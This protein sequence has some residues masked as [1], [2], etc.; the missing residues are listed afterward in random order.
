MPHVLSPD[1]LARAIDILCAGTR[2][3]ILIHTEDEPDQS[4]A[5]RSFGLFFT[6]LPELRNLADALEV[7]GMLSV[8]PGWRMVGLCAPTRVRGLA[9]GSQP[10]GPSPAWI[11]HVVTADAA[12]SRLSVPDRVGLSGP[13]QSLP[14]DNELSRCL[15]RLL[16]TPSEPAQDR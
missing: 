2:S 4:V 5:S 9:D 8:P 6:P 11:V 13:L 1:Q 3:P 10:G 16:S 12:A 7:L 14:A 15:R